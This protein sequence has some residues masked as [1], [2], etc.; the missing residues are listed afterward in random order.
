ME[1]GNDKIVHLVKFRDNVFTNNGGSG[2]SIMIS[3][4][5]GSDFRTPFMFCYLNSAKKINI[6]SKISISM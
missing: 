6:C 3:L 1:K 5:I 4:K 2:P